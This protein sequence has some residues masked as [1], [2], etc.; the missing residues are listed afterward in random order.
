MYK[1]PS[2]KPQPLIEDIKDPFIRWLFNEA[3]TQGVTIADIERVSGVTR[4]TIS[5]WKT[6]TRAS[7]FDFQCV[8]EALGYEIRMVA[9]E[10]KNVEAQTID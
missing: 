6:K 8:A 1:Y 5:R 4:S 9:K 2:R 10:P 7:L 3:K